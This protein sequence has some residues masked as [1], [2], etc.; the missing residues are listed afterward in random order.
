[1]SSCIYIIENKCNHKVYVGRTNNSIKRFSKHKNLLKCNKHF[2]HHLQNAWNKYGE[3]NFSFKIHTIAK[4]HELPLLEEKVLNTYSKK[5]TYNLI[6]I[7]KQ[8]YH[9]TEETKKK[10]S[11]HTSKNRIGYITPIA[12][13]L[14]IKYSLRKLTTKQ[15]L[16]IIK[17]YNT[18]KYSQ[19]KLAKKFKVNQKTIWRII[20]GDI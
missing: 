8:I 10:L 13:R 2:N 9:H 11:L 1:M 4:E 12:T 17:L 6:T 15:R 5:N 20:H 14:K 18:Q 3:L 16:N 19:A 7:N